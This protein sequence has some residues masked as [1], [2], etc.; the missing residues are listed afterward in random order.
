MKTADLDVLVLPGLGGGT[1]D[2]WYARW[3]RSLT[4]VQRVEQE[5]F[6]NPDMEIW[7]PAVIQ[8]VEAAERPVV[9]IG[10]S[11]GVLAAASAA[12]SL[13]QGKALGAFL[14]APPD[15]DNENTKSFALSYV[16]RDP[17][18]FPSYVVA[19]RNDPYCEFE[20]AEDYAAAWGSRLID[21]GGYGHHK[22]Q[23]GP[24]PGP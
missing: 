20:V 3:T 8:A 10:H 22:D 6:S 16:A 4:T 18:P 13:P 11:A 24:R 2:H 7:A 14:V 5:D 17:L 9:L 23:E 12:P 21:W 19:S 15:P 1:K